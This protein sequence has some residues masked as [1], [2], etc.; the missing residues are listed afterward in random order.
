MQMLE[1]KTLSLNI[2]TPVLFMYLETD[3]ADF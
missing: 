2:L 3:L 1:I